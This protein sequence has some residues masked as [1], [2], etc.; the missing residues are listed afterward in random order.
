MAAKLVLVTGLVLVALVMNG[1]KYAKVTLV[2]VVMA[3]I[4]V[5]FHKAA[6]QYS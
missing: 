1:A 2:A 3:A 4:V 5:C 6:I